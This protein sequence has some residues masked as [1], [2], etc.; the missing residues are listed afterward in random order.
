M[1]MC[2]CVCVCRDK[3]QEND[4]SMRV[5]NVISQVYFIILKRRSKLTSILFRNSSHHLMKNNLHH[6]RLKLFSA[7]YFPPYTY[8]MHIR[9]RARKEYRYESP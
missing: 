1:S 6:H 8:Y 2:V 5:Y 9:Q 4:K 3:F 7:K